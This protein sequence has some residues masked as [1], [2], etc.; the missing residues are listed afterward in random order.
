MIFI[1][2]I[3]VILYFKPSTVKVERINVKNDSKP[4]I[5]ESHTV[6]REKNTVQTSPKDLNR[7]VQKIQDETLSKNEINKMIFDG[8][9]EEETSGDVKEGKP[10]YVKDFSEQDNNLAR[11]VPLYSGNQ[12][13]A[14]SIYRKYKTGKEKLATMSKTPTNW[15]SYPPID[16]Y[17]ADEILAKKYSTS[18]YTRIS[19]Y[20]YTE[21]RK[22]PYYVYKKNNNDNIPK[23]VL[24]NAHQGNIITK[25]SKE[26]V[27]NSKDP[28]TNPKSVD[29]LTM[30]ELPIKINNQGLFELDKNKSHNFS[31]KEFARFQEDMKL[32]NDYIEK[33][34]IEYDKNMNLIKDLRTE[35]D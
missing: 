21:S 25:S 15:S 19:G 29:D 13:V 9:S 2:I 11:F 8:L 7:G 34:L 4:I 3:S 5:L 33:G 32:V 22:Y 12:I 6:K 26:P 17:K 14:V 30:Q 20:F 10:I 1:G 16:E 31:E 27:F 28:K 23:Y 18:D 24:V 35:N